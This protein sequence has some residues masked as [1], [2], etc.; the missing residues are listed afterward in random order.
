MAVF[1]VVINPDLEMTVLIGLGAV[2]AL[3]LFVW[4][5]IWRGRVKKAARRAELDEKIH[6]ARMDELEWHREKRFLMERQIREKQ[7]RLEGLIQSF[8]P[9]NRHDL[10]VPFSSLFFLAETIREE[11]HYLGSDLS[12]LSLMER[13]LS[14]LGKACVRLSGKGSREERWISE[15]SACREMIRT[16]R[17]DLKRSQNQLRNALGEVARIEEM[18]R[19]NAI[20]DSVM[21][22]VINDLEKGRSTLAQ[23]P[24]GLRTLAKSTGEKARSLFGESTQFLPTDALRDMWQEQMSLDFFSSKHRPGGRGALLAAADSAI[25]SLHRCSVLEET[26]EN[27]T[28][29]P[30]FSGESEVGG[31]VESGYRFEP[32]KTTD[33]VSLTDVLE[34]EEEIPNLEPAPAERSFESNPLTDSGLEISQPEAE[35][36]E[37]P[38]DTS[39]TRDP[40]PS[41]S[42]EDNTWV[43]P[44]D[45]ELREESAEERKKGEE[46]MEAAGEVVVESSSLIIFRSNDPEIWNTTCDHGENH[47]SVSL[48]EISGDASWLG[49]KRIDTGEEIFAQV[50]LDDLRGSG[51]GKSSGFNGS[52]EFFYGARH[53]GFFS[54]DC[55]TEVETRFTYGG[56]GFGHLASNVGDSDSPKQSWAWDGRQIPDNTVFEF[57]LYEERPDQATDETILKG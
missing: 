32:A 40:S 57:T 55:K 17:D 8:A 51:D 3:S 41:T 13:R 5:M 47:R 23:M 56:W 15:L 4:L 31:P 1:L 42:R 24:E 22:T 52:N 35:A 33:L 2:V 36:T 54:E 49:I 46:Q 18:A 48:G 16:N 39:V 50:N 38:V 10:T 19:A 28:A 29:P 14:D 44:L 20:D 34:V 26:K 12:K 11:R 37:K 21:P 53:L 43:T 9:E 25:S 45:F 7:A 6:R 30:A 27:Q